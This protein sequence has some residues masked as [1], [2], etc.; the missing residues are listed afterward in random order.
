MFASTR[1]TTRTLAWAVT[2][3]CTL[4]L[5]TIPRIPFA[6]SL[7]CT[8]CLFTGVLDVREYAHYDEDSGMGVLASASAPGETEEFEIDLNDI[9]PQF[10]KVGCM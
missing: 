1:T 8:L 10:L 2:P 7:Y 9:E 6:Y 3:L 4:R 5:F